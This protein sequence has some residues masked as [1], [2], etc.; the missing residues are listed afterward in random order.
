MVLTVDLVTGYFST[1]SP[2]YTGQ[3]PGAR[4]SV[5]FDD[6]A[7]PPAPVG[8]PSLQFGR[9]QPVDLLVAFEG[10]NP[11]GTWT[12]ILQDTFNNSSSNGDPL[13]YY[14][15]TLCINQYVPRHHLV[16]NR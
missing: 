5:T 7:M 9:F 8:G 14:S 16:K 12:L 11:N 1:E 6:E 3:T 2:T 4:V 15:A 13:Q 10:Q